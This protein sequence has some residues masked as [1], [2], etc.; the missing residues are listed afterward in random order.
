[1]MSKHTQGPWSQGTTIVTNTTKRWSAKQFADNQKRERRSVYA[2]F[3][4][5]DQGRSRKLIAVCE[6]PDDAAVAAAAP[7]LLEQ[8]EDMLSSLKVLGVNGLDAEI[9]NATAVVARAKGEAVSSKAS[10]APAHDCWFCD[11]TGEYKGDPCLI[12]LEPLP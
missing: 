5:N 7:D 1:M 10:P 6:S 3:S 8:L 11:G 9:K 2:N 12:C 4:V